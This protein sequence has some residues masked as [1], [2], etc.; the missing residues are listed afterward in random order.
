MGNLEDVADDGET[1]SVLNALQIVRLYEYFENNLVGLQ[2]IPAT[3]NQ[4]QKFFEEMYHYILSQDTSI[5]NLLMR[6]LSLQSEMD[7]IKLKREPAF[8]FLKLKICG[9]CY[10]S[11]AK[12]LKYKSDE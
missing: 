4:Q 7:Y 2:L 1:W 8:H 5:P 6:A 12:M 9:N 3:S 10:G 11:V